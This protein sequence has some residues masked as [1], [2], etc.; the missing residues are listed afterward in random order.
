[1]KKPKN[2]FLANYW[3]MLVG[4]AVALVLALV[5]AVPQQSANRQ[6]EIPQDAQTSATS[7]SQNSDQYNEADTSEKSSDSDASQSSIA[8][9][10][11]TATSSDAYDA[12]TQATEDLQVAVKDMNNSLEDRTLVGNTIHVVD[13]SKD[14]WNEFVDA[15]APYLISTNYDCAA[16]DSATTLRKTEQSVRKAITKVKNHQKTFEQSMEK[17]RNYIADNPPSDSAS[18]ETLEYRIAWAKEMSKSFKG[19]MAHEY[20]LTVLERVI[21]NTRS[22]LDSPNLDNQTIQGD[23]QDLLQAI[24]SVQ[25]QVN[26]QRI[27]DEHW[28]YGC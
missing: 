10:N 23:A 5:F 8:S 24:D 12:C 11:S 7:N 13:L 16:S 14:V 15:S 17:V 26:E 22:D 4:I 19:H 6:S 20:P 28:H 2:D 27:S 3:P 1:M 25:G 18:R 21:V 9:E